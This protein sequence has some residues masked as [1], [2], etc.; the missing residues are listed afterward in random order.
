[1]ILPIFAYGQPVLKKVATDIGT[2]Y[3]ELAQL[4][5]NMWETMYHADGVGLAAPQVGLAI[6]LFV[7][8]SLQIERDEKK[9]DEQPGFKRVFINAHKLE[10]TGDPWAYEEGCLSIPRIRGDVD[11]PPVIRLRWQDENF[12]THEET[13]TG[14]NARIIQHEYDHIEGILFTEKLKPL[15]KRLIQ[16]KLDDIRMGKINTDYK[17]KFFATR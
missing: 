13:F 8:D 15:K 16:R 7:I 17:M 3:P 14:I 6:R 11:R 9:A 2:D 4:I 1:M 5:D 10:E 12:E